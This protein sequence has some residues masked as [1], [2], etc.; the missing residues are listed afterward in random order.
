MSDHHDRVTLDRRRLLLGAGALATAGLADS[1][2]GAAAEPVV[3]KSHSHRP[4]PAPDPIPGGDLIPP[5]IHIHA[6]GPTGIT[7]PFTK[8]P[9][10]GLDVEPSTITDFKGFTAL[11]YLAGSAKGSD[12]QKYNLEIDIRAFEGEYV[13]VDALR[14]HGAFAEI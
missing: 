9:L 3:S 8:V 6:P 13:G 5:L 7:L 4:L 10:E 14:H 2:A 1:L 11:A 12:G